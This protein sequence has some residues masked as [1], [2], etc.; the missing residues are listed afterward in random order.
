MIQGGVDVSKHSNEHRT[1]GR[2]TMKRDSVRLTM[3]N[4]MAASD[5]PEALQKLSEWGVRVLDLK[6]KIF[7]KSIEELTPGEA[8][9]V[10]DLA[11]AH[12][13][14]IHTLSTSLFGG[15]IEEGEDA[16]RGRYERPLRNVI[17]VARV[18]KPVNV[19][20][21]A[22]QSGHRN[23]FSDSAAYVS[24]RHPWLIRMYR[25]AID[26]IDRAGFTP[27]IENEIGRC[28]FGRPEEILNFFSVLDRSG[29]VALTWDIQNL[30][31]MGLFPTP[32]TY[33]TLKPLIGMIH[34]K[35]GRSEL[36]GGA[37]KWKSHLADASWPVTEMCRS[38]IDDGTSPVICLNASHG[39][40]PEGFEPDYAGDLEFLRRTFREI[41]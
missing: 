31:Q 12:D 34:L 27:M 24:N 7:G 30:W 37:L 33:S 36:P 6:N 26:N 8:H 18:L 17:R 32:S 41:E 11:S 3:L 15:D 39:E 16:F 13:M 14:T 20:L 38:V 22:S 19:R 1:F 25:D 35:G 2:D 10:A 40:K 4:N 9:A 23:E 5:F 29:T 28:I 21:L